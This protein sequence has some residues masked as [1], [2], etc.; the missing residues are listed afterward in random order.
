[1]F[2]LFAVPARA[3]PISINFQGGCLTSFP[4]G[5]ATWISVEHFRFAEF[6]DF[7]AGCEATTSIPIARYERVDNFDG[8]GGLSMRQLE[9]Q[10][11]LCGRGQ[12]DWQGYEGS[13]GSE[14][15]PL[16]AIVF[17]TGLNCSEVPQALI[18]SYLLIPGPEI[19]STIPEPA[20]LALMGSGLAWGAWKRRQHLTDAWLIH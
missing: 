15:G 17:N 2:C 1:M 13:S 18:P 16:G 5:G 14:L 3:G 7:E 4:Q 11:P 20:I 12:I 6:W 19:P 8:T 9:T 10:L